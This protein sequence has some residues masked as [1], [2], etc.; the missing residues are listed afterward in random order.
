[1]LSDLNIEHRNDICEHLEDW[2]ES[3]CLHLAPCDEFFVWSIRK[4]NRKNDVI[5]AENRQD[6]W[7]LIVA[8]ETRSAYCAGVFILFTSKGLLFKIKDEG[9]S[10][11]GEYFRETILK[12]HVLPFLK[13][14]RNLEG[15][16]DQVTFLHDM[17]GCM[18]AKATHDLLDEEKLDF[19]RFNGYGRWPGKS[20]DLNPAESVGAIMQERVENALLNIDPK[21][22]TKQILVRTITDVLEDMKSE[23]SLFR[24][25]LRSFRRRLDLV[26]AAGGKNI[27]Q[28]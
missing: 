20:A 8:P 15:R 3:D 25:L 19:F 28:Y 13:D 12:Q 21:D 10:W 24:N 5:W 2:D 7:D 16:Y 18:R 26:K 22:I 23:R 6:V 9:Q 17:A 4:P 14:K 1:M 27:G 11:D